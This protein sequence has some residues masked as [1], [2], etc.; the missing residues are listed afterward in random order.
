MIKTLIIKE[1][2]AIWQDKKSRFFLIVTPLIQLF[3]FSFAATLDVKNVSFAVLNRDAGKES[4]ELIERFKGSS[5]FKKI[6]Y[7]EKNEDV[8]KVIDNQKVSMVINID[9]TFSRDLLSN[10][11]ASLQLILDGRKSNSAQIIQGYAMKIINK[12]IE[13]LKGENFEKS[14]LIKRNWFNPNL[15]YIWFTVPGLVA[16][17]TMLTAL[18]VTALTI[19]RERE[20]GTFE[21]LLVSPLKPFDILIG[22]TVPGILIGI[23]E[24]SL[25][26]I[27]A[28]LIFKIP[29]IG[30]LF[31]LY[32]SMFVFVSSIVGIGLFLSSLC[33]T[34]QQALL[35]VFMFMSIS[36]ILSGFATPIENMPEWLQK[37]T[38]INPLRHFLTI[39][40]GIFLKNIS[41]SIVF[42][43]LWHIALIAIF[44]LSV[45]S[46]FLKKRTQ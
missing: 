39:V 23:F 6:R 7:L 37:A 24:G 3:I 32:L 41:F 43:N 21:K 40:R 34:Q 45:A 16:I 14:I 29:F 20:M 4:F 31:F 35:S 2:L 27:A 46:Y 11:K 25:I 15:L 9:E 28:I 8:K 30:S 26:L 13:D 12:Y 38:L 22:K 17:L 19:A 5:F 33:K 10:K 36:V 44:N 18:L 1:L 42:K